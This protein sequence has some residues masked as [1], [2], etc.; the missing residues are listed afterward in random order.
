VVFNN[1]Y[2]LNLPCSIVLAFHTMV[3]EIS[4]EI[5]SQLDFVPSMVSGLPLALLQVFEC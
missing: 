2:E 4:A 3:L 1:V 5:A